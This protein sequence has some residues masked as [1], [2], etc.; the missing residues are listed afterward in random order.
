MTTPAALQHYQKHVERSRLK[1]SPESRRYFLQTIILALCHLAAQ[2]PAALPP[3]NIYQPT[4]GRET[5]LQ[6]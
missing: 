4:N 3:G 5:I 2:P 6:H 1:E